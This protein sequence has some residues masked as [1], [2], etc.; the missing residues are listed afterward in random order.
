[1]KDR[2]QKKTED[3]MWSVNSGF[4][5]SMKADSI[6]VTLCSVFTSF[7]SV[8]LF[9]ENARIFLNARHVFFLPSAGRGG[10]D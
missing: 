3:Q 6:G 10:E 9:F 8:T 4:M 2:C 7:L 1:M 5:D